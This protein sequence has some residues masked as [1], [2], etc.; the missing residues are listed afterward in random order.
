MSIGQLAQATGISADTI[1]VW[2]RRYGRPVPI[3][4]PSGHRRYNEEHLTWLRRIAEALRRGHRPGKVVRASEEDLDAIVAPAQEKEVIEQNGPEILAMVQMVRTFDAITLRGLL[5]EAWRTMGPVRFL[6]HR[7]APLLSHIG[8]LWRDG[9]LEV[10]HEHF[11]TEVLQDFLRRAREPYELPYAAP[12]IVMATLPEE[13]HGI[14]L[15]MCALV[16]TTVGLRPRILG[17]RTPIEEIV[18]SAQECDAAAVGISVSLSTAGIET[19]RQLAALR[20][21][22]PPRTSIVVGG[23]GARGTRRGPRGVEYV[24]DLSDF[25]RWAK[26]LVPVAK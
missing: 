17:I 15:Q 4:L 6:D 22:L 21:A 12:S 2:E 7:V 18:K 14:G 10:R 9:K 16:A 3:R 5:R 25:Q 19:D 24:T 26:E 1:R 20:R 13:E 8:Q 23:M 11:L